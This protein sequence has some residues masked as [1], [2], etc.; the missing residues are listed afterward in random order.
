MTKI[1]ESEKLE[2]IVENIPV[3]ADRS[4]GIFTKGRVVEE[5]TAENVGTECILLQPTGR[6]MLTGPGEGLN[7]HSRHHG[8]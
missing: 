7:K 3:K 6:K 5:E 1:L 8:T 4:G 2:P